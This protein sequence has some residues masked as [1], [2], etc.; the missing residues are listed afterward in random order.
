[1]EKLIELQNIDIKLRDLNDLLG[2]LP[3]KVEELNSQEDNLKVSIVTNKKRLKEIELE[4]NKLELKNSG[5]DE[6]IDKLKDQLFLVTNNKQYDAL[7]NEI[8][9]LKEEKSSFETDILNFL[10]EKESLKDSVTSTESTLEEITLDLSNRRVKLENAISSSADEK[11]S[12]EIKRHKE[13]S[14]IEDTIISQYEQVMAARGGLAVVSLSGTSCGGCGATVPMQKITEIR[15]GTHVH[16]CDVC[17]R[18]LYSEKIK[19]NNI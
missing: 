6:K 14:G 3:S 10:E 2:D 4:T 9:H 5:F 8:D 15:A 13:L 1:M 12:L 16:R 18:F 7:M 19:I 11:K 17:A